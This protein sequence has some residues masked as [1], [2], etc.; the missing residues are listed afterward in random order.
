[1]KQFEIYRSNV[2]D[3]RYTGRT[4]YNLFRGNVLNKQVSIGNCCRVL[5][6]K[7]VESASAFMHGRR[8]FF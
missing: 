2:P 4:A 8:S 3:K 5:A 7:I 1:M 6:E